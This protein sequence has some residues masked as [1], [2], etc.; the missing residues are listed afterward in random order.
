MHGSEGAS[1]SEK[2]RK[3]KT[4]KEKEIQKK[5]EREGRDGKEELK[6]RTSLFLHRLELEV[7][8]MITFV[9]LRLLYVL[10]I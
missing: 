3:R 6:K 1:D 5:R 2:E 7:V 4:G 8:S 10:L 9:S